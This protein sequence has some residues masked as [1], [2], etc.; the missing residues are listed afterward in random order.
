[1]ARWELWTKGNA[2]SGL[3]ALEVVEIFLAL[4]LLVDH[5]GWVGAVD[6]RQCCVFLRCPLLE[7][8]VQSL[9]QLFVWKVRMMRSLVQL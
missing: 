6:Q 4:L 3:V 9:K 2:V 1:L 7:G 8:S 5:L